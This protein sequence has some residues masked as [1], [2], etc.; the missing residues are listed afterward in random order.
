[1]DKETIKTKTIEIFSECFNSEAP[2]ELETPFSEI[3]AWDSIGNV[4]FLNKLQEEFK[5]KFKMQD[6]VNFASLFDVVEAIS[7]KL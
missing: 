5:I 1:M 6:L 4:G 7:S 2:D 3:D